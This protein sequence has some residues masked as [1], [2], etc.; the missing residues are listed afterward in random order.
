MAVDTVIPTTLGCR[1]SNPHIRGEGSEAERLRNAPKYEPVQ[2]QDV[3]P[4][5]RAPRATLQQ[6]KTLRR[7][8]VSG[9]LRGAARCDRRKVLLRNA[10]ESILS[11]GGA[12]RAWKS[13]L[14]SFD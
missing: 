9:V 6:E 12:S 4:G 5:S 7:L 13:F 2:S 3:N 14:T 1:C 8:D 11:R 10:T